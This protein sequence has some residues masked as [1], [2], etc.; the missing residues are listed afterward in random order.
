MIAFQNI[1]KDLQNLVLLISNSLIYRELSICLRW[2]LLVAGTFP[3]SILTFL[4]LFQKTSSHYCLVISLCTLYI[5]LSLSFLNFSNSGNGGISIS[6]HCVYC[7]YRKLSCKLL[8]ALSFASLNVVTV[9][10][11]TVDTSLEIVLVYINS[12]HTTF[13]K[14]DRKTCFVSC[15][16]SCVLEI[17]SKIDAC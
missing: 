2:K 16:N 10:I 8:K 1:I 15:R 17:C 11:I 9:V 13:L 12:I 3:W 5:V 14:D 6:A 7:T 4:L